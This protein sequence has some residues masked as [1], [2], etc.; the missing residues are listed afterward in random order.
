MR[1]ESSQTTRV[2]S[3]A[4]GDKFIFTIFENLALNSGID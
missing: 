4:G 2:I 3:N 1:L